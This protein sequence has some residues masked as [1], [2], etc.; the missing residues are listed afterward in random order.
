MQSLALG[1]ATLIGGLPKAL[2]PARKRAASVAQ[3]QNRLAELD[4]GAPET[5]FEER[6]ALCAYPPHRTD[7]G[8][9][10]GGI[11]AAAIG[12]ALIALSFRP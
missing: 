12:L 8:T 6:R 4:G 9:R 3:W 7:R 5:Y 11:I 10:I 1:V 2:W